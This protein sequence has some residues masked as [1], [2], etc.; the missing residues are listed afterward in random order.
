MN[1]LQNMILNSVKNPSYFQQLNINDLIDDE[2]IKD[3]LLNILQIIVT[4][5]T[6]QS[7]QLK[8]EM[9]DISLNLEN[10]INDINNDIKEIRDKFISLDYSLNS[11]NNKL[12]ANKVI[13]TVQSNVIKIAIIEKDFKLA[14]NKYDKIFLDNLFMPNL[15]SPKGG[16]FRNLKE[17]LNNN[18][19]EINK[20]NSV[21]EKVKK[22]FDMLKENQNI[23]SSRFII[24][25]V[26]DIIDQKVNISENTLK[27]KFKEYN[28][29]KEEIEKKNENSFKELHKRNDEFIGL[30]NDMY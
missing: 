6:K 25:K 13:E 22:D 20:I 28:T 21:I 27:I 10:K 7:N 29:K 18:Y 30:L 12:E 23:N 3:E 19:E 24:N 2:S 16:K 8:N 11:I 15:I 5:S 26:Q 4:N 9:E 17:L 1:E 14:Q